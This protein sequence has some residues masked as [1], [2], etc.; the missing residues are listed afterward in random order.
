MNAYEVEYIDQNGE[1]GFITVHADDEGQAED[2]AW[3][4][5]DAQEVVNVVKIG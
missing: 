2:R 1:T 5:S 3:I 4:N